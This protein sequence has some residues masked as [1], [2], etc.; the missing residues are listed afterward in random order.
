MVREGR[1]RFGPMEP[2]EGCP[3]YA[4][5]LINEMCGLPSETRSWGE[6]KTLFR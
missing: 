4:G 5:A 1:E 3:G 2:Y 6:V